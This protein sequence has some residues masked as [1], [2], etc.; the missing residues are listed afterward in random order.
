MK[1]ETIPMV[2]HPNFHKNG[3]SGCPLCGKALKPN[4]KRRYVHVG[5]GGVAILRADLPCT[6]GLS[7][8]AAVFADG[9]FDTG[10][11]GWFEVG[12][13]CARKLGPEYSKEL[14]PEY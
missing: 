5:R 1:P 6:G 8:E 7:G 11:M 14:P 9:S 3:D 4:E 13:T 2:W 12:S 10:D